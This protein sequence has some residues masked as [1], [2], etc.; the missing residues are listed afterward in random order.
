MNRLI[1]H[2]PHL[3]CQIEEWKFL[4]LRKTNNGKTFFARKVCV[5]TLPYRTSC[6]ETFVRC[7]FLPPAC[8]PQS[9]QSRRKLLRKSCSFSN[10]QTN[11]RNGT[12]V[13]SSHCSQPV[14]QQQEVLEV[15]SLSPATRKCE[16]RINPQ[17]GW[18][19]V[20]QRKTTNQCEL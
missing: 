19:S 11:N 16:G 13:T 17:V 14:K 6:L 4:K 10:T 8:L 9:F 18:K 3:S 7:S 2:P 20:R 5:P 15:F 12:G 1:F